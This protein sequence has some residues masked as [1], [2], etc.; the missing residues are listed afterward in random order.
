MQTKLSGRSFRGL[1]VGPAPYTKGGILVLNLETNRIVARRSFT[2]LGA[3][4]QDFGDLYG[5][6]D[7]Q[8]ILNGDADKEIYYDAVHHNLS[9]TPTDVSDPMSD[10]SIEDPS[11]VLESSP[12]DTLP[13]CDVDGEEGDMSI[14][15][16]KKVR[17]EKVFRYRSVEK[18]DAQARD[19]KYFQKI[20]LYFTDRS[21]DGGLRQIVD[22][23]RCTSLGKGRG[24]RT[25]FYKLYDPDMYPH[26]SP[27]DDADYFWIPC[28]EVY[29]HKT[30]IWEDNMNVSRMVEVVAIS[31]IVEDARNDESLSLSDKELIVE[32][33]GANFFECVTEDI[34]VNR[35]DANQRAPP[36]NVKE[37]RRHPDAKG[38]IA[39]LF[40]ELDAFSRTGNLNV[41]TDMD[42]HDIPPDMIL[43]LMPLFSKKYEGLNF[44]KFKC[45]MVVLGNHWKN[46]HGVSTFSNM[47]DMDTLKFIIAIAAVEGWEFFKTDVAEAFLTTTVN[48]KREKR[49]V[50]VP[51]EP[52]GTYYARRPPG[53][54]D[55][56]MP[57]IIQPDAYIYGHPRAGREFSLD[58]KEG[59]VGRYGYSVSNYCGK[60]YFHTD[61]LGTAIIAHATDDLPTIASTPAK[62]KQVLEMISTLYPNHT[63]EDP[64]TIILGMTVSFDRERKTATLRQEAAIVDLLNSCY[65]EWESVGLETLP[66]VPLPPPPAQLGKKDRLLITDMLEGKEIT[67]YQSRVGQLNWITNTVHK[68][69]PA[70][71][72][73][74]K[75]NGGR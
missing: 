49:H 62:K 4:H 25:L 57:Y 22:V 63:K 39:S 75:R 48:K 52:D 7:H 36:R 46:V 18:G 20:G 19:K 13:L 37:M 43:Q 30:T 70:Q 24:S 17:K 54:T 16:K 33:L 66:K 35:V 51:D 53:L 44:S 8:I 32:C 15:P 12:E 3:Y 60:V 65:P 67:E 56:D 47:V 55:D 27:H 31:D 14:Q 41:P 40:K 1:V 71:R 38:Y 9:E 42:I 2:V 6:A 34:M 45:R 29:S 21:D 74:A 68:I 69:M 11:P 28:S 5:K 61:E 50:D 64:A 26:S 10:S 23:Q 59:I 73:K 72:L 58:V